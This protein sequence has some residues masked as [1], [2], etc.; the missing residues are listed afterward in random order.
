[1][2]SN[3][4]KNQIRERFS[5]GCTDGSCIWGSRGGM[6][7][8]GGCD[9]LIDDD[10]KKLRKTVMAI[11][12][13]WEIIALNVVEIDLLQEVVARL[14]IIDGYVEDGTSHIVKRTNPDLDSI[15]VQVVDAVRRALK[16]KNG[17]Y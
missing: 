8:N 15:S 3:A 10:R 6:V 7:T 16:A 12:A 4:I 2:D 9:C 11:R 14:V 1:M 5:L 13:M 17:E